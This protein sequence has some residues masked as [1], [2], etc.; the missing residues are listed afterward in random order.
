[1]GIY[2]K[3]ALYS[4]HQQTTPSLLSP[5]ERAIDPLHLLRT[6]SPSLQKLTLAVEKGSRQLK[7]ALGFEEVYCS[8]GSPVSAHL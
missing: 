7:W 8:G 1:L 5:A 6:L 4:V 2:L 3:L